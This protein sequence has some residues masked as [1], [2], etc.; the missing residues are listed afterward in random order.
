MTNEQL[1]AKVETYFNE[2]GIEKSLTGAMTVDNTNFGGLLP[3]QFV[4]QLIDLTRDE[5]GWISQ[6]NNITVESSAG[7]VPVFDIN[8]NITEGRGENDETPVVKRGTT[9]QSPYACKA[10]TSEW[11]VTLQQLREAAAAGITD[12]D[13]S[14]TRAFG[15]AWMNDKA[16]IIWNSDKTLDAS[17]SLNRM[18][19]MIDGVE[20]RT[21]SAIV[22][23]AAGKAFNEAVF[24]FAK[25]LMPQ[26]FRSDPD[27]RFLYS[28]DVDALWRA[29]LTK[30]NL[31]NVQRTVLGDQVLT[32]GQAPA[33]EGIP[34][35]IIPQASS[36]RGPAAVAP[37]AVVNNGTTL[38]IRVATILPDATTALNRAV[39]VTCKIS[40]ESE[41]C[42][43]TYNGS[44]Q[45]VITTST[46]MR[47][48]APS[49]TASDYTVRVADLATIH[50]AN[51][52]GIHVIDCTQMRSYRTFIPRAERWEII[53][54]WEMDVLIPTP[55][56]WVKVDGVQIPSAWAWV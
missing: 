37:T 18:L 36:E 9:R 25:R 32:S 7:T 56:A 5:S 8:G 39:L 13:G 1:L 17:T 10:F 52:K 14:L 54:H 24:A 4:H 28:S 16:N 22:Y 45:N 46:L 20:K 23:D 53:T 12:F 15:R 43:V 48:T 31:P 6:C 3:R 51:P 26:R 27:K 40:G 30:I 33:P 47:Q 11:H 44:S 19:R 41:I 2:R 29:S 42:R 34:Q 49:T 21:A 35:I 50:H 55:E 38:T